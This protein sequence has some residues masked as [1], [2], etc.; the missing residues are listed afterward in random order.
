MAV[1][2]FDVSSIYPERGMAAA[3]FAQRALYC[4]LILAG[5]ST[6]DDPDLR[7][8][9]M[10]GVLFEA[11]RPVL[12]MP[13][14]PLSNLR[15]KQVLLAWDRSVVAGRAARTA[16]DFLKRAEMVHI[17]LVNAERLASGDEAEPGADMALYLARHGIRV[18]VERLTSYGR[19]VANVLLDHAVHIHSD[20]IVMGAYGHWWLRE[21]FFGGVTRTM[22]EQREVPMLMTH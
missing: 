1:P 8:K 11:G 13:D 7:Q 9:L 15:P 14:R 10:D 21:R 20:L 6:L 5:T 3:A 19:P 17:V 12:L 22:I 18:E 16:L 4:D 2:S